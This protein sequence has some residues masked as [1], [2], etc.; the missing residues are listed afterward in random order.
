MCAIQSRVELARIADLSPVISLAVVHTL[1]QNEPIR[2]SP[3][4]ACPWDPQN[5]FRWLIPYSNKPTN[6]SP[7]AGHS[8]RL[9]API[10]QNL[11]DARWAKFRFQSK[12]Q[13]SV[14]PLLL[15]Q[16]VVQHL[17]HR[18]KEQSAVDLSVRCSSTGTLQ[19]LKIHLTDLQL[20][21]EKAERT[22][23]LSITN[24]VDKEGSHSFR[25]TTHLLSGVNIAS[26]AREI[27]TEF[28][29][30]RIAAGFSVSWNQILHERFHSSHSV[31]QSLD[32]DLSTR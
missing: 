5:D 14:E 10:L 13:Y 4:M 9:S 29:W 8:C 24:M 27:H 16:M 7:W 28:G 1:S 25:Q 18:R 23:I 21:H 20:E 11:V 22:E 19:G 3:S 2:M 17:S 30:K 6:T 26:V 32:V 15:K 31:L 12:R